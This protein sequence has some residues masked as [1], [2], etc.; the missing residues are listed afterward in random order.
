MDLDAFCM[1]SLVSQ[2]SQ[3]RE[4][5]FYRSRTKYGE[6]NVFTHVCHSVHGG[7]PL[8]IMHHWSLDQGGLPP[9][10]GSASEEGGLH[11]GKPSCKSRPPPKAD[12][13]SLPPKADPL[14]PNADP[15]QRQTLSSK[16]KPLRYFHCSGRYVSYRNPYLLQIESFS[17]KPELILKDNYREHRNCIGIP[18]SRDPPALPGYFVMVRCNEISYRLSHER[19]H[20]G[21]AILTILI[22]REFFFCSHLFQAFPSLSKS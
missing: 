12:P 3:R 16:V 21:S 15:V 11:Q 8:I 14:L 19:E 1:F 4:P 9:D 18:P 17:T 20:F 6:G 22:N 13:L 5:S 2:T 7:L 10:R